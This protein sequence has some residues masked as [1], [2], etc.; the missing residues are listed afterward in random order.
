MNL[1][2]FDK[3]IEV[4]NQ[5]IKLDPKYLNAY[6]NRGLA[7]LK[8]EEYSKA[9]DDFSKA[10]ELSPQ[11]LKFYRQR[12][13]AYEK[14]KES[15][16]AKADA[17]KIVWLQKLASIN[18]RIA[19][20]PKDTELILERAQFYLES[21]MRE[22]AMKDYAKIVELTQD[23]GRGYYIR[24]ALYLEENKL[25]RC[26][27]ECSRAINIEPHPEAYSVRGDAFMKRGDVEHALRDFERAK[28][29]DAI[30]AKAYLMRSKSFKEK[31][32]LKKAAEDFERAVAIDPSLGPAK[33]K[34][35]KTDAKPVIRPID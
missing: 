10:I 4:L 7:W 14:M 11:K 2:E 21:E 18:E 28:R 15:K 27:Q 1:N 3:A 32:E 30:V 24:G 12:M 33:L 8:Q 16:K 19:K 20:S 34:K 6:D 22:S 31:G 35:E 29:I 23:T 17:E 13:M 9:A 26:I 5:V 25:D